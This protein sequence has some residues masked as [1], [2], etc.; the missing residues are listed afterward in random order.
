MKPLSLRLL[1]PACLFGLALPAV[2]HPVPDIPVR[3]FF[4]GDGEARIEVEIDLRCFSDDPENEPY[5][6]KWVLERMTPEE[7]EAYKTQAETFVTRSVAMF[8]EPQGRLQPE[9]EW[10]FTKHRGE[11]LAGKDDPVMLTGVW[12]T[13]LKQAAETSYRIEALPDGELSVLFLNHLNDEAVPRFQV[14]FP[15]EKSYRLS[16]SPTAKTAAGKG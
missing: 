7:K 8:I 14:L 11:A 6:L 4:E 9:F 16:L 3:S 13:R 15:G 5:L 1:L 2:A 12:K 10:S